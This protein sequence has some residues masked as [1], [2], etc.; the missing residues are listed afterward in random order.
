MYNAYHKQL[1]QWIITTLC[2]IEWKNVSYLLPE[3]NEQKMQLTN[4]N[5]TYGKQADYKQI[6]PYKNIRQSVR[7]HTY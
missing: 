6:Y 3:M 7:A 1:I 5:Y 2:S 4:N